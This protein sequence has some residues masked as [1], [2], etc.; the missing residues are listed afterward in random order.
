MFPGLL[1]KA[2]R[3]GLLKKYVKFERN[4]ANIKGVVNINR[5]IRFNQPFNGKVAYTQ[6]D[7]TAN[8]EVIHL[9]RH[10]IE[11][12]KTTSVKQL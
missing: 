5:H 7:H 6:R 1:S 12:I 11:Y 3:Q 10:T 8:N 9:I 2:L 4:D